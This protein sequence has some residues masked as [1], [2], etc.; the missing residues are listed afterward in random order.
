MHTAAINQ[1]HSK[2]NDNNVCIEDTQNMY[3]CYEPGTFPQLILAAHAAHG[4]S[5]KFFN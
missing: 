3:S 2:D 4:A 1:A 5:V